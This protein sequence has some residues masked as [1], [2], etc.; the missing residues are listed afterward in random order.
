MKIYFYSALILRER[1]GEILTRSSG[2]FTAKK[3]ENTSFTE[4]YRKIEKLVGLKEKE[5]MH[6]LALS[7]IGEIELNRKF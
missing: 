4:I 1:T 6:L 7:P 3:M 2:T 5:E